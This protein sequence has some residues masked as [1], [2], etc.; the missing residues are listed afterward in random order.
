M[1]VWSPINIALMKYWGKRDHS[2]ML[3]ITDSISITLQGLHGPIGTTTALRVRQLEKGNAADQISF[4]L[5]GTFHQESVEKTKR[6]IAGF[7]IFNGLNDVAYEI[8]VDSHNNFPTRAGMASSASGFAALAFGLHHAL[9]LGNR[10]E[11]MCITARIG[12]G[13]ACRSLHGGFVHWDKGVKPDGSDSISKQLHDENWWPELRCLIYIVDVTEKRVVSREGME[14]TR[15]TSDLFSVMK[16][17]ERMA[18][19]VAA[20]K[21]AIDRKDFERLAYLTMR[22]SNQLHGICIDSYPPIIYHNDASKEIMYAIH[23]LN[24]LEGRIVAGYTF[25]A[26]PNAFIFVLDKDMDMLKRYMREM[27]VHPIK[28]LVECKVGGGPR[29]ISSSVVSMQH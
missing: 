14:R 18:Q 17:E 6:I 23:R 24:E 2:L 8:H 26:G 5:N 19:K 15:L 4:S 13:S 27:V 20:F 28:E 7:K 29:L 21:D 16:D 11:Q 1:T 12:S 9:G 10:I 25:D 22:D 3:P